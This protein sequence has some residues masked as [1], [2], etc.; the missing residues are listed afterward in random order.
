MPATVSSVLILL[1]LLQIKHM[2]ADY[3]LQTP[4]MLSG[5]GEYFHLGRAEHAAVH[6]FG[7]VI[8]FFIVGASPAFIAVMAVLE[9]IVHFNIDWGKA[10]WSERKGYGPD[11]AGFW[12]AAGLDQALHQFTY[13]AMAW[14]WAVY[15]S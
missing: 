11:E 10:R 15:A 12:R 1:S 4:R 6:A 3:F 5:R 9:W 7:S 8:A 14:A 13:L 2:F